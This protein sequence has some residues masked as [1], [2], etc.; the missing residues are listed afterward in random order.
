MSSTFHSGVPSCP[1][2]NFHVRRAAVG[3]S[4]CRFPPAYCP[5]RSPPFS[6]RSTAILCGHGGFGQLRDSSLR[7]ASSC[8]LDRNFA[9]P[10]SVVVRRGSDST[11]DFPTVR[12]THPHTQLDAP[13]VRHSKR[14]QPCLWHL[15]SLAP[16]SRRGDRGPSRCYV[17]GSSS[18]C[19]S[20]FLSAEGRILRCSAPLICYLRQI[21]R[22]P[23]LHNY[24]CMIVKMSPPFFMLWRGPRVRSI[25]GA[26]IS[27]SSFSLAF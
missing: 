3:A 2:P 22:S 25:L 20:H 18:P 6:A 14:K 8:E 27:L 10:G 21:P 15:P 13:G 12:R 5:I 17:G 9:S 16:R 26:I 1:I 23:S 19:S 24:S 11:S 4:S 7:R